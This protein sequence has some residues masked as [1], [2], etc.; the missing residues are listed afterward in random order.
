MWSVRTQVIIQVN[1]K[2]FLY[3]FRNENGLQ[4]SNYVKP[5]HQYF[6][7]LER[8]KSCADKTNNALPSSMM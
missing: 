7:D 4:G 5:Q 2:V 1:S 8:E 3:V 6:L